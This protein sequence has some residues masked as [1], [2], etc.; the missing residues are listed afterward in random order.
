MRPK[1]CAEDRY[2][3]FAIFWA[4]S[5][6]F[7]QFAFGSFLSSF[8]SNPVGLIE[9]CYFAP[10]VW[11]LLRPASRLAL[12][13]LASINVLGFLIRLP[14]IP[15]HRTAATMVSL[16]V[17]VALCSTLFAARNSSKATQFPKCE[18]NLFAI[19]R[20]TLV[21]LYF[22]AVFHKLNTGFLHL[23]SSCAA[24]FYSRLSSWFPLTPGAI[25][26]QYGAIHGTLAIETIIPLLLCFKGSRRIGILLGVIFHSLLSLDFYQHTM[27]FSSIMFALYVP[28]LSDQDLLYLRKLFRLDQESGSQQTTKLRIILAVVSLL[29]CAAGAN[30]VLTGNLGLFFIARHAFWYSF[31]F[32][33]L[34]ATFMCVK[35]A[36]QATE[37]TPLFP[38]L[39]TGRALLAVYFMTG[40]LPYFGLHYRSSFDMYSSLRVEAF[41][42]NHILMPAAW[43]PFGFF[44]DLVEITE[45]NDPLLQSYASGGWLLTYFEFQDYLFKHPDISVRYVRGGKE[46]NLARA[47]DN[48]EFQSGPPY[49]MRKLIW[50][51]PID[52][53]QLARC[54]W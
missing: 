17:L 47:G 43:D 32:F 8:N 13:T 5:T 48:A 18:E 7:Q 30:Q 24:A 34:A 49:L 20:S 23:E 1:D 42:S 54:Q 10:A 51:R 9:A 16:A 33:V 38:R 2:Q 50:L 44:K 52:T 45:S 25:W 35:D 41:G 6:F 46:V 26:A 15:S 31:A 39:L 37:A 4:L 40:C 19:L 28:F 11:V 21:L 27:D 12:S 53:H 14:Q 22:F 36:E 3:L 29:V